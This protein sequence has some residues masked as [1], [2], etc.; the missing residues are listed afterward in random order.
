MTHG[1]SY[2]LAAVHHVTYRWVTGSWHR[3]HIFD[4]AESARRW[5]RKRAPTAKLQTIT[6]G[7]HPPALAM[8]GRE[9]DNLKWEQS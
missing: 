3:V 4:N 5:L 2:Y 7:D 9:N 6:V 8:V 1:P